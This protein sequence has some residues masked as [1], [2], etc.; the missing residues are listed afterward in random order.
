MIIWIVWYLVGVALAAVFAVAVLPALFF[1]M[2]SAL[3]PVRDR[4]LGK[5]NLRG[6]VSVLYEPSLPAREFIA[7]YQLCR[8]NSARS[9]RFIG[10]WAQPVFCGRY[11]VIAYN[12]KGR[13][14]GVFRVEES[15]CGAQFTRPLALPE[16]TDCVSVIFTRANGKKFARGG[17]FC[18]AFFARFALFLLALAA[19][20]VALFAFT[21]LFV[22]YC[23]DSGAHADLVWSFGQYVAAL[24]AVAACIIGLPLL[25][26]TAV[27]FIKKL[28]AYINTRLKALGNAAVQEGALR[29]SRWAPV[30]A[31]IYKTG[32]R[33]QYLAAAAACRV[34]NGAAI[35]LQ[36]LPA[37]HQTRR[38]GVVPGAHTEGK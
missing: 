3:F 22:F 19:A 34:R 37:R 11:E 23:L 9:C 5:Y 10:E 30:A 7:Q 28:Y 6:G 31:A 20:A 24:C 12:S 13:I 21:L 33:L 4:G 15:S 38:S 36:R 2:L 16:G 18:A 14:I 32:L 27:V 8:S 35:L 17:T 25:L 26:V 1:W 29:K